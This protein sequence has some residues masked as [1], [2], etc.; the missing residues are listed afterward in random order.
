MAT[1]STSAA[2]EG[3]REGENT[4]ATTMEKLFKD[5]GSSLTQS[6]TKKMSE[7]FEASMASMNDKVERNA[8]DIR[9]IEQTIQRLERNS[10]E[11]EK[12]LEDKMHR[13]MGQGEQRLSTSISGYGEDSPF[14]A[15]LEV[16]KRKEEATNRDQYEVARRT[17]RLWPVNDTDE[18]RTKDKAPHFIREKLWVDAADCR[19]VDVIRV[20]RTKQARKASIQ[21][22]VAVVFLDKHIR[23]VV[24]LH[25]KN[26]SCFTDD[27]GFP[28]VGM[29]INYPSHLGRVFR[30]LDWYGR[31]MR[32]RHG[33]G[34]R[35][36][37]KFS[38]DELT[39]YVNVCLPG[40]DLLAQNTA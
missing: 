11:S 16:T 15:E 1:T 27:R 5:L 29:R 28:T 39:L 21:H 18:S 14:A 36:N 32:Q 7:D 30:D 33:S 37:V 13:L 9:K 10:I 23:D 40:A 19:D 3:Q 26:L 8:E 17:L 4:S 24:A 6:L 22:E 31:E 12:R 2:S 34:T 38:D 35:R 20:R 25:G